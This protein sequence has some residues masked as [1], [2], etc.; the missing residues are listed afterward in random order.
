MWFHLCGRSNG[1]LRPVVPLVLTCPRC[2]LDRDT[3]WSPTPRRETSLPDRLGETSE[4]LGARVYIFS[5]RFTV[6]GERVSGGNLLEFTMRLFHL[7]WE[8]VDHKNFDRSSSDCLTKSLDS[9]VTTRS[10]YNFLSMLSRLFR[11]GLQPQT[12]PP[13]RS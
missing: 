4:G 13:S 2:H 8:V 12:P 11:P 10:T 3:H 6:L 7:I 1:S 5:T 9:R